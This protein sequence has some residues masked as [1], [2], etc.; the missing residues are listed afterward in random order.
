MAESKYSPNPIQS[1]DDDWGLDTRDDKKRPFSGQAVQDFIKETFSGKIGYQRYYEN[2]AIYRYFASSEAAD[3]YDSDPETYAGLV[4]AQHEGQNP[5]YAIAKLSTESKIGVPSGSTGVYISF[6]YDIRNSKTDQST[7]EDALCTISISH[8]GSVE[9]KIMNLTY[10]STTNFLLDDYLQDGTNIVTVVV[11]GKKNSVSTQVA[12]TYQVFNVNLESSVDISRYYETSDALEIEYSA[13]ATQIKYMEGF[14]DGST[15]PLFTETISQPTVTGLT[16]T[17]EINLEEGMHTF[18]LRV[19]ILFNDEKFYSKTD[20]YQFYVGKP[21]EVQLGLSAELDAGTLLV[22]DLSLTGEQYKTTSFSFAVLDTKVRTLS[23]AILDNDEALSTISASYGETKTYS[24]TPVKAGSHTIKL[25]CLTY[26]QSIPTEITASSMDMDEASE[27]GLILRLFARGR[28]NSETNKDTWKYGDYSATFNS[29]VLFGGQDGWQSETDSSGNVVTSLVLKNGGMM[30]LNLDPFPNTTTTTGKTI[31]IEFSSDNVEND[32]AELITCLS[33]SGIGLKITASNASLTSAAGISTSSKYKPR[34]RQK[35]AFVISKKEKTTY[36]RFMF[37]ILNGVFCYPNVYNIGDSF[38]NSVGKITFGN[39]SGEATLKIYSIRIYD[40]ALSFDEE[41]GNY[42]VDSTSPTVLA[43]TN[44]VFTD[45]TTDVSFDK[46]KNIL[47]TLMITCTGEDTDHDF[48]TILDA[49]DKKTSITAS[50][51]Y[52]HPD[53]P[54]LN[55][56]AGSARIRKQGTSSLEYPR[57]NLKFDRYKNM[58]DEDGNEMPKY[59][60]Y[61]AYQFKHSCAPCKV[62]TW[63]ADFM[64][65]SMS[66]NTGVARLWNDIMYNVILEGD[67]VC[68][69]KAQKAAVKVGHQYDVRTCVD[70]FPA[71]IFYRT[72]DTGTPVFLGLYNFNTDKSDL[73]TFGWSEEGDE[74]YIE[75][76]DPSTTECWEFLEEEGLC[77]MNSEEEIAKWN[78]QDGDGKYYWE[79]YFERRQPEQPD[80]PLDTSIS[81][82]LKEFIEWV[83]STKDDLDKWKAEKA[84][85]IDEWKMAAYYIYIMYYTAVDQ[86]TKNSMLIQEGDGKWFF[87]N[88]DNDT[89]NGLNNRGLL[90]FTYNLMRNTEVHPGT[91][92]PYGYQGHD[93]VLFNNFEKDETFMSKVYRMA[94]AMYTVGLSYGSSISMFVNKQSKAFPERLHNASQEFKYLQSYL[95]G[96]TG[97]LSSC[98]GTRESHVKYFL[99]KRSDLFESMWA[100]GSYTSK[101]VSLRFNSVVSGKQGI[102]ITAGES[103]YFGLQSNNSNIS[104]GNYVEK[105]EKLTLDVPLNS[106]FGNIIHILGANKIEEI[107]LSN[108]IVNLRTIDV[109]NTYDSTTGTRLKRIILSNDGTDCNTLLEGGTDGVG[110]ISGIEICTALEELDIRRYKTLTV[111]DNMDKLENLHIL[112]AEDSGLTAFTPASGATLTEITL[113]SCLSTIAL[114]N[115]TIPTTG[116]W[117]YTPTTSLRSISFNKVVG[118]DTLDFINI[119]VDAIKKSSEGVQKEVFAS[120]NLTL[121]NIS[122]RGATVDLMLYLKKNFIP[123]NL[124][125]TGYVYFESLS[126]EE[127]NE[128]LETFGSNVFE[129]DSILRFDAPE[130]I[131]LETGVQDDTITSGDT[132][133]VKAT[134]FPVT[135]TTASPTYRLYNSSGVIAN[136]NSTSGCYELTGISLNSSTGELI[137]TPNSSKNSCYVDAYKGNLVSDKILITIRDYTAAL[138]V[139]LDT[140]SIMDFSTTEWTERII[141]MTFGPSGYTVGPRNITVQKIG[142]SSSNFEVLEVDQNKL[143]IKVRSIRPPHSEESVTLGI[144]WTIDGKSFSSED[145]TIVL[146]F[147]PVNKVIITGVSEFTATGEEN[148]YAVSFSPDLV[149]VKVVDWS[150]SVGDGQKV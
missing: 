25:T 32:D 23:V 10:G 143:T 84:D 138:Q 33:E 120:S 107:D 114:D 90:E 22:G 82:N 92:Y 127:Y 4:L 110:K 12:A 79:T 149:N 132:I 77:L 19:Y 50:L 61:Q 8:N 96:K 111:L 35:I 47:P 89:V 56:T 17:Q 131:F 95:E 119:W 74:G 91:T 13:S 87:I 11:K 15:T 1:I 135:S 117:S 41:L 73:G 6:T 140:S 72:G 14:L 45:G 2:E 62:H 3:L 36:E 137:T 124:Q 80:D 126:T 118:L 5:F 71:V 97:Y 122:W 141:Q 147:I 99:S 136:Y 104:I 142:A 20:F 85:H 102:I 150:L 130:N 59:G 128:L 113:P 146:Q 39:E 108:H 98:Q 34:E 69:T 43:S 115:V 65:S 18:Q 144:Y 81:G 7:G 105:G 46:L 68:R 37:T 53:D 60:K 109:R 58:T 27:N 83:Y 31:E 78:D 30:E 21:D 139:F 16:K 94:A 29:K 88:Y 100:F 106:N 28:S 145:H 49:K 42:V 133:K 9:S 76:Y 70:G 86:V 101:D 55:F 64:D 103:H 52:T 26:S 63:K 66:H 148:N 44:D 129:Q 38:T 57:P 67:Y 125:I 116:T 112:K 75:G 121:K 93:S 24:Y 134:I 51:S 40:R 123:E 48:Q 54:T